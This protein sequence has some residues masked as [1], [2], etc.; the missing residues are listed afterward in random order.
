M[1]SKS[2][3]HGRAPTAVLF[4]A[5]MVERFALAAAPGMTMA[6]VPLAG[7]AMET[8]IGPILCFEDR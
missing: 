7:G 1:A 2:T 3:G 8:A 6:K 4:N 5:P